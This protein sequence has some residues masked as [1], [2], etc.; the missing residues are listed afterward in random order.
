MCVCL[1][2]SLSDFHEQISAVSIII[3]LKFGG[4]LVCGPTTVLPENQI[5]E[6]MVQS[7]KV[8]LRS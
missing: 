7:E 2:E 6:H 5:E 8:V 3:E 1:S 4:K